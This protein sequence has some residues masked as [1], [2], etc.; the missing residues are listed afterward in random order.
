MSNSKG[1][2]LVTGA[3]GFVGANLTRA[4]LVQNINVHAILRSGRLNWRLLD[5]ADKIT[6]HAGDLSDVAFV[7]EVIKKV[8]PEVIYHSATYGGYPRQ[9]DLAATITT[10][11]IGS[12]NL[13]Q[14]CEGLKILK[15]FINISSSSEYGIKN[16]PMREIDILDPMTPYGITKA[17]QT[18]FARYFAHKKNIPITTLRLLAVYGP[19]EETGRLIA[20]VMCALV[21][22]V[23]LK[24]SAPTN[25]RDLVFVGDVIDACFKA[26][27]TD[28]I[29]GEIVNIGGGREYS[30][31]E[32]VES[33]MQIAG[34]KIPLQWGVTTNA[35]TFENQHWVADISKAE[36]VLGWKPAHSLE[37]GIGETFE[38]YKSNIDLYEHDNPRI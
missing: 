16:K 9:Q 32:V 28:E 38:W 14:A 17:T 29:N 6:I 21:R 26:V 11:I 15:R 35:R 18:L 12:V 37:R 27:E 8:Q 1:A 2:V 3:N 5:V 25:V 19:Y 33:A 34:V 30:I 13:F 36:R 22:H 10:N 4:L 23:P 31:S 24:L 7:A 20:D